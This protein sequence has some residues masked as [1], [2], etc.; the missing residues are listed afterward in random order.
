MA[1]ARQILA[2]ILRSYGRNAAKFGRP[3]MGKVPRGVEVWAKIWYNMR[4]SDMSG[5]IF[6][7]KF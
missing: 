7:D 2:Q 1:F 4:R 3:F 5:Q 6:H